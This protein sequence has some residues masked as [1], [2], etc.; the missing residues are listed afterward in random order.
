MC[1]ASLHILLEPDIDMT[2][3]VLRISLSS[4]TIMLHY[5]LTIVDT[6]H[7]QV[8]CT[9]CFLERPLERLTYDT[10][11]SSL[12][13]LDGILLADL[14]R[15][16]DRRLASPPSSHSSARSCHAAVKVHTINTN[17]WVVL[18]TKINVF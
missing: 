1:I 13:P 12:E 7:D 14:V 5:P 11:E 3:L 16:A 6:R 2:S 17:S 4:P 8:Q 10:L 15:S 18:D 9:R